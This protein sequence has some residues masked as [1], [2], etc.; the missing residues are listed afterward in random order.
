MVGVVLLRNMLL[1]SSNECIVRQAQLVQA[2]FLTIQNTLFEGVKLPW[3]IATSEEDFSGIYPPA[4]CKTK[5]NGYLQMPAVEESRKG[6]CN[7]KWIHEKGVGNQCDER[8]T[9]VV[10]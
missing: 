1:V 4:I 3:M 6:L 9:F 8:G 10:P 2:R 5:T 7:D